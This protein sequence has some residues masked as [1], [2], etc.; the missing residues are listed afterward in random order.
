MLSQDFHSLAPHSILA[1]SIFWDLLS[2]A[3][4]VA[5]SVFDDL[6]YFEPCCCSRHHHKV[7]QEEMTLCQ[8]MLLVKSRFRC[9]PLLVLPTSI[10]YSVFPISCG[11]GV[12]RSQN[13]FIPIRARSLMADCTMWYLH[14]WGMQFSSDCCSNLT[15]WI[16]GTNS[17]F[18]V[19]REFATIKI[20][21]EFCYDSN[22]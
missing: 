17:L 10:W 15:V 2:Q 14:S 22:S 21:M 16:R 9:P 1:A 5:C 12:G 4:W 13:G 3:F 11:S 7:A 19:Q 20:Q 8:G 6:F 18:Y